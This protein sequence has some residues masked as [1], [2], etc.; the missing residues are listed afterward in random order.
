[1]MRGALE[2]SD[3]LLPGNNRSLL[4]D[5]AFALLIGSLQR[6]SQFG[7]R[8]LQLRFRLL[9]CLLPAKERCLRLCGFFS[10][11]GMLHTELA[12]RSRQ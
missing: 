4:L 8:V 11:F 2:L 5:Q 10:S 12:D 7:F 3:G 9:E 1:M 6:L